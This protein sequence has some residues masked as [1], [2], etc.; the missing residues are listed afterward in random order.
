MPD[1]W[2][3]SGFHLLERNQAGRLAVTDDYLR[4]YLARPE[5]APVPESCAHERSLFAAL[6]DDPRRAVTPDE[7]QRIADAD[8]RDSYPIVLNLRDRL[9]A[10]GTVE[11]C[12]M[13]LFRAPDGTARD[14]AAS[15][16]PPLFADQMVQAVLRNILDACED[17]ITARAAELLFREQRVHLDDGRIVLADLETVGMSATRAQDG[18][19]Y[20]GIGRLIAEA[21]TALKPVDLDVLHNENAALY[22]ARDERHDTALQVNFGREGLAALCHVLEQW[23]AHFFGTKV[24]IKPV[25]S[26]DNARM[27]WYCGLDR[28]ATVLL[29][30]LYN[31]AALD[32]ERSR[33]LLC[34]MELSFEDQ[35]WV[36]DEVRGAPVFLALAMNEKNELRLKPQNLLVNLPFRHH[37]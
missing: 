7:I 34:L 18:S 10:A 2:R 14:F 32:Y 8:A 29:N 27:K 35:Q 6:M 26:L 30:D 25:R 15:G 33:R 16:L 22:W 11:G 13:A 36:R 31:G 37:V 1:F 19:Q 24:Q 5:V 3:H 20:G 4:A 12:Y 23:I 21:K 9:L 28:E 17:G